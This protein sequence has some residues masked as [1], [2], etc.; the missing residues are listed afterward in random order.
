MAPGLLLG[1][2]ELAEIATDAV[3][4]V[5]NGDFKHTSALEPANLVLYAF[6]K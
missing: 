2:R 4:R 1:E 6:L 5:S 3:Q